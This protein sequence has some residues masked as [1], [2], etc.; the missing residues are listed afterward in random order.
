[1]AIL[2]EE[3]KRDN[4]ESHNSLKLR[5]PN[6][7]DLRLNFIDC[8]SFLESNCPDILAILA[9]VILAISLL[10]VIFL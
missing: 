9:Q 7:R 4:S 10:E 8:E 3:C 1:M 5:F 6:I 2:S